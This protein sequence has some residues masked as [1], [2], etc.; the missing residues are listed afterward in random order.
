MIK[1]TTAKEKRTQTTLSQMTVGDC[2]ILTGTVY[3]VVHP[4]PSEGKLINGSG[5]PLSHK[6]V[7]A[8]GTGILMTIS[9]GTNIVPCS[10]AEA[11]F[12]YE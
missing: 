4:L 11:T 12:S 7:V 5:W 9:N 6:L 2:F 1:V 10:T 3:M 8:V